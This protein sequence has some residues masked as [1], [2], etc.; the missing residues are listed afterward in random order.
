MQTSSPSPDRNDAVRARRV[1]PPATIEPRVTHPPTA[2]GPPGLG[3]LLMVVGGALSLAGGLFIALGAQALVS[4]SPGAATVLLKGVPLVAGSA[5]VMIG[6][7]VRRALN[8]AYLHGVAA[9]RESIG[10]P[11]AGVGAQQLQSGTTT[12]RDR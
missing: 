12:S 5:L 10:R 1:S 2:P 4:I 11:G 3:G 9:G 8:Q 6:A 7:A